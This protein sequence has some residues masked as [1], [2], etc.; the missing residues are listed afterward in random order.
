MTETTVTDIP[1]EPNA[2]AAAMGGGGGMGM[3]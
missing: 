2:A 1:E 3:M